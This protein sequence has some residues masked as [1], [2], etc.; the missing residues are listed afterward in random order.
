MTPLNFFC[1]ARVGWRRRTVLQVQ[2]ES[3]AVHNLARRHSPDS[4]SYGLR[5]HHFER[6]FTE[7]VN[8]A[9]AQVVDDLARENLSLLGGRF[10]GQDELAEPERFLISLAQRHLVV[11]QTDLCDELHHDARESAAACTVTDG[12][13]GGF[14]VCDVDL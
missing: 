1:M 3:R 6:A 13:G 10:D 12:V 4:W 2:R 14:T 9:S 5:T 7:V 8:E 11:R